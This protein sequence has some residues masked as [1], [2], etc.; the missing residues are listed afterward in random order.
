MQVEFGRPDPAAEHT[1]IDDDIAQDDAV[2]FEDLDE[3]ELAD[4]DGGEK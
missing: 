1:D 4:D 3:A 2:E